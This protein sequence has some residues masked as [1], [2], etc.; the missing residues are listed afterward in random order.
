MKKLLALLLAALF[1]LSLPLPVRADEGDGLPM[2]PAPAEPAPPAET[3]A[4]ESTPK[5]HDKPKRSKSLEYF[6][7]EE[8]PALPLTGNLREDIL[9]VARSQIGYSADR[10]CYEETESGRKRYYTRYGEWDGA[11]FSDWCDMF[12][13]FCVYFG[14]ARDYPCDSSCSRQARRLKTGGYWREWNCYMPKKGD[15]VFFAFNKGS[16]MPTHVGIVEQVI[17]GEGNEAGKLIT[18]EGNVSNPKGITSCV[19]RMERTLECV[20]GYGTYEKG[21]VYDETYSYRPDFWE[22]ITEDSPSFIDYPKAE[23]LQFLGM[24]GTRYY[25]YWFPEAQEAPVTEEALPAAEAPSAEAAPATEAPAEEAPPVTGEALPAA[26][27]LPASEPPTEEGPVTEEAPPVT[28]SLLAAEED[29]LAAFPPAA[30]ALTEELPPEAI[31]PQAELLGE[32]VPGAQG[33]P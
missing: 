16:R 28:A 8:L 14:G 24:Y 1:L 22:V 23:V 31:T 11:T 20:V 18:I 13:S 21:K 15:L 27:A 30:E 12:V 3:A 25:E 17:P 26:E 2:E 9:T 7:K 33:Q 4:P 32:P 6:L 19:R 10:T 5:P 29:L